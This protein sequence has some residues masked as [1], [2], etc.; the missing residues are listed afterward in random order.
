MPLLFAVTQPQAML[1][2]GQPVKPRDLVERIALGQAV[3][4]AVV[5]HLQAVFDLPQ[6]VIGL[7]EDKRATFECSYYDL[8]S[9]YG[10]I[11][12]RR[13]RSVHVVRRRPVMA[14]DEAIERLEH[15]LGRSIDWDGDKERIAG[16]EAANKLLRRDY[17][18]GWEYP[19]A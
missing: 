9:A 11:T 7:A 19:T 5:D 3:G 12:A 1:A 8:L 6:P 4:L 17:R 13:S 16:D 2:I 18:K 10:A 15:L 14:L